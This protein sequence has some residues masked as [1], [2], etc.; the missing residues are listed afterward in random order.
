MDLLKIALTISFIGIITLL[1]IS[2]N[3]THDLILI[4]NITT[5][6]LNKDV[7]IKGEILQIKNYKTTANENFQVLTVSDESGE[8]KVLF[9]NHLTNDTKKVAVVG[10]VEYYKGNLQIRAN[11]IILE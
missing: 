3:L 9:N 11:K 2:N 6:H 7:K 8:I 1:I 10:R 4:K 5:K